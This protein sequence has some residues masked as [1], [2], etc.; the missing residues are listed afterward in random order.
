MFPPQWSPPRG[1]VT[2]T[3]RA[4]EGVGGTEADPEYLKFA[5]FIKTNQPAFQENFNLKE[6]EGWI[7]A[8]EDTFSMLAWIGLQKVTF[9]AYMLEAD[10]EAWW[11]NAKR[12]I[13]DSHQGSV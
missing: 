9:A 12:M 6:A 4:L 11:A 10:V 1:Q 3:K 8:L 5:K 13:E 7:E 2:V